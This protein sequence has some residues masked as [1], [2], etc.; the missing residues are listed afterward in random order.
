MHPLHPARRRPNELRMKYATMNRMKIV[1]GDIPLLRP[2]DWGG[3]GCT[4]AGPADDESSVKPNSRANC[5][6][7]LAVRNTNAGPYCRC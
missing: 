1:N 7:T 3:S 2:R 6:P 4:R 5:S